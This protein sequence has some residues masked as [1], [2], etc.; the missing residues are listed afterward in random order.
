[1]RRSFFV[2]SLL[3]FVLAACHSGSHHGSGG[4]GGTGGAGGHGGAAPD[5]GVSNAPG[6][7]ALKIGGGGFVVGAS[8]AGDGTKIFKTDTSG[9]YLYHDDTGHFEQV[10][11]NHLPA[12]ANYLWNGSGAY[13]VLIAWSNSSIIYASYANAIYRSTDKG[14]TFTRVKDSLAFDSNGGAMRTGG[15][16]G[17]I[18][19][20]N[21]DHLLV[22]DSV[23]MYRSTDGGATWSTPNGLVPAGNLIDTVKGYTG[24][25]FN[26]ASALVSGRTSEAIVATAGRYF[27]TTDG[28]DNWTEI[29]SGGPG[30]EAHYAQFDQNGRYTVALQT[31]GLWQYGGG[32]WKKLND[33]GDSFYVDPANADHIYLNANTA[34][35]Q[36]R[37]TDN[38]ATWKAANLT[39]GTQH[40]VD[41]IPW[42]ATYP[43]Y[44]SAQ[45]LVDEVR[46]TGWL[47]GGNQ[48]VASFP[49]TE[50]DQDG[51]HQL[52][53]HGI[54]IEQLCLMR[55][56]APKGSKKLHAAVMDE[57]Y[58]QLDRDN[59]VYPSIVNV[60]T[61]AGTAPFGPSF[62]LDVSK[63]DPKLL[64]R[65][66]SATTTTG[67][68][69][70][71]D[72]E[73]ATWHPFESLPPGGSDLTWGYGGRVAYSGKDNIILTS[74]NT[75]GQSAPRVPYYT[76]DRGK[77]W[78]EVTL[79]T[80]A[81]TVDNAAAIHSAW[82]L[83]REILVADAEQLGRF[84]FLVYSD[85]DATIRGLYTTDDG[86]VT[87][88]LA[89]QDLPGQPG[90]MYF[91]DWNWNVHLESPKKGHLWAGA[92]PQGSPP[93][94]VAGDGFLYRSMD[95]GK[96]FEPLPDVKEPANFGFGAPAH[97][98]GYPVLYM[99]G[100]YKD[101]PA[102]WMSPDAD[103][104]TP[105]WIHIGA[106][107]ND[108]WA[109]PT[110]ITGD[111]DVPGRVYIATGCNGAQVGQFGD[112]LP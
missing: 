33:G 99:E 27:R 20:Q 85:D 87:W 100:F 37:S 63:E 91:G 75:R 44:Y 80:E 111:P 9:G 110:Y 96:T 43:H 64:A 59:L 38:G 109:G 21:P 65:W 112:K 34:V 62:G 32:A 1:M 28:G 107:P 36:Q 78:H 26:R 5:G 2:G 49:L 8:V 12:D 84:Y 108:V 13:D 97:P 30:A 22:S 71:S 48:G 88:T 106:S 68:S 92:G 60:V 7:D 14:K 57:N 94:N 18:D 102:V 95:D 51:S 81:W 11:P 3:T 56:A 42:H 86:G 6:W 83:D 77:T 103:Q 29:S 55:L 46:K 15:K 35:G 4:A 23:A 25:A 67:F 31:T 70:W 54:G 74:S 16:H 98:G 39:P 58:A 69:G 19:P 66:M 45:F 73:G 101:M 17:E 40:S 10:V 79:P 24:V 61:Q 89:H 82:Y 50:L 53:I 90:P 104:P 93:P 105:T 47:P 72:D 76:L 52:D 41:N